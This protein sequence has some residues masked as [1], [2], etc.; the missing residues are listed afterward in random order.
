MDFVLLIT[1]FLRVNIEVNATGSLRY[2]HVETFNDVNLYVPPKKE[3]VYRNS[4]NM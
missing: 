1:Y 4:S 3:L 2:T